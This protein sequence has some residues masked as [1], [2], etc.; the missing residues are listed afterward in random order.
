M[1]NGL[2]NS[3][4]EAIVLLRVLGPTGQ[5]LDIEA[6][7]DTGFDGWLSLPP[8]LI[9]QLGLGWQ[10][11]GRALLADGTDSIFD[12]YQGEVIW[13]GHSRRIA[14]DEADTM[15]LVG[16]ALMKDYE[17]TIQVRSLGQVSLRQLP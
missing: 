14:V 4:L 15:P 8:A 3:D 7:I 9:A 11:R 6:V 1:I 5:Q 17:L 2:V 12:I 10:R 13:D 16:M